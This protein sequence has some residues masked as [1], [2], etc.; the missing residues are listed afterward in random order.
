M[1]RVRAVMFGMVTAATLLSGCSDDSSTAGPSNDPLVNQLISLGFRRDMIVDRGDYFLVEG[2]IEIPKRSV[3][4]LVEGERGIR[5]D[6]QWRTTTIV[7]AAQV[8]NI[9]V[10][11]TG[12]GSQP[13]WQTAARQ[14]IAEWNRLSCTSVNLV[15]GTPAQITFSTYTDA[16]NIAAIASFPTLGGAPGPTIRVNTNY[17]FTPNNSS[18]KL[19]N[20]AHEIGHTLGLR[21]TNW[22]SLNESSSNAVHIPGTPTGTDWPSVMNGATATHSWTGFS[23]Y[24]AIAAKTLYPDLCANLTGPTQVWPSTVCTWRAA[25]TGGTPPYQYAWNPGNFPFGPSTQFLYS[26]SGSGFTIGVTVRDATGRQ[27]ASSQSVTVSQFG[28]L[29]G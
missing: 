22:A 26:S 18:T 14:A 2:D 17:I 28:P 3:A 8:Q 19:R 27:S 6:F 21:H 11:L 4:E 1:N 9:K 5:P 24:D 15:E 12:L 16:N 20:M 7:G 23:F 13:A 10:N 25:A 29:C